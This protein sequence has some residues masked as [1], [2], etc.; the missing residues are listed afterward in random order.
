MQNGA[1]W[2]TEVTGEIY[3]AAFFLVLSAAER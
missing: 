3:L 1:N 2:S